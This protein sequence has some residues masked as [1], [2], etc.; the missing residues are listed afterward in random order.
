MVSTPGTTATLGGARRRRLGD[1]VSFDEAREL[2]RGLSVLVIDPDT[3][4]SG[5]IFISVGQAGASVR[6]ARRFVQGVKM[7]DELRP[8]LVIVATQQDDGDA[9]AL[10]R[11]LRARPAGEAPLLVALAPAPAEGRPERKRAAFCGDACLPKPIDARLF[12]QSLALALRERIPAWR[13]ARA[14]A[15][16]A[17]AL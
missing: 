2:L 1:W 3:E 7:L 4:A 6:L 8:D 14:A 9:G 10:L 12:A 11:E 5:R 15:R 17:A 13:Q 16:A